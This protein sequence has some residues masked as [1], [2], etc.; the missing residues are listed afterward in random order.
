[1]ELMHVMT[2]NHTL[3]AADHQKMVDDVRNRYATAAVQGYTKSG[4]SGPAVAQHMLDSGQFDAWLSG[5]EKNELYNQIKQTQTANLINQERQNTIAKQKQELTDT[6]SYTD[7][8]NQVL[9]NQYDPTSLVD[10][11][12][13]GAV[14][15]K[16]ME[17]YGQMLKGSIITDPAA[18]SQVQQRIWAPDGSPQ[19]ISSVAQLADLVGKPNGI[20]PQ[21]F[22]GLSKMLLDTPGGKEL[23][24][25]RQNVI[26]LAKKNFVNTQTRMMNGG[27][28]Y[29]GEMALYKFSQDL[30][31][32]EQ[33]NASDPKALRE[34]YDAN[35][36]N[37]VASPENLNFYAPKD[38]YS[39]NAQVD[40]GVQPK[41]VNIYTAPGVTP[42]PPPEPLVRMLGPKGERGRIK[43][44]EVPAAL[45]A[46]WSE[47][48]G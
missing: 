2:Q 21:D 30:A 11:P 43:K 28:D 38:K 34:M 17:K 4:L 33:A 12:A 24:T 15:D 29:A 45:K 9:T 6:K 25:Q 26:A 44:S 39:Y 1:M 46:G 22:P 47:V 40:S 27:S 3:N 42:T 14:K 13:S 23:N 35:S 5:N 16:I 37:F 32:K 10:S 19:K 36:K 31:A 8:F 20:N 18:Y 7:F 48:G 41:P